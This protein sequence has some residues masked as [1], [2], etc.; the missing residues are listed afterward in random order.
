MVPFSG[1]RF[2]PVPFHST[3]RIMVYEIVVNIEPRSDSM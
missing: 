3:S 2:V 1:N